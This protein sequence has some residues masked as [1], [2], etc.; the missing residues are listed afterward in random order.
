MQFGNANSR[1]QG[2]NVSNNL[3]FFTGGTE[4]FEIANATATFTTDVEI[5]GNLTISGNVVAP[6]APTNLSLSVVGE[7]IN[8]T[9]T[10]STTSSID[11]YL[12]Y[13]SVDGSDYGLI[14]IIP[15]DDFGS[16]MSIIDSAFTVTG[17]QAYRVYAVKA[18]KLSSA[19]SGNISY[20]VSTA[21]PTNLSVV[22]LNNAFYIQYDPPSSNSRFVTAYKIYKHE[23][24]T[25]G[26]LD[27]TQATEIYSGMNKSY[28]YQ[29]SGSNNTNFHQF[30]VETTIAT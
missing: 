8:V 10:A 25:Q 18:G 5:G 28:M 4:R 29:I 22:A 9:F 30:W 3:Q 11:A 17:T 26:S 15:P 16:T 12:V 20:T 19:L 2:S 13:S 14:S 6:N 23:H 7:T 21:E 27:R 1:I 24:A